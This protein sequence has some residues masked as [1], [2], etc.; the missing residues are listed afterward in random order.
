MDVLADIRAVQQHVGVD[1]LL[2]VD[3]KVHY[4]VMR[5]MHSQPFTG[6][7]VHDWLSRVPMLYGAWHAYKH[8][9]TVVH[10]RFFPVF[11]LLEMTG[12][13]PLGSVVRVQR[14][15]L[16]LEKVCAALLLVADSVRRPL[17]T[18]LRN[19]GPSPTRST[20][21]PVFSPTTP[22]T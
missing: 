5:V 13:P 22:L 8:T 10:R 6:Y 11:A 19:T 4:A 17:E 12:S 2:L 3:E 14:K 16:Y 15:I 7:D 18:A 21:L 20:V 1:L 9:L